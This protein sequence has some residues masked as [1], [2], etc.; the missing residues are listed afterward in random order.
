MSFKTFLRKKRKLWHKHFV[1]SL[2]AGICVA[3]VTFLFEFTAA[4]IVL[5][6]SVGASAAILANFNSHHLTKLHTTITSYVIAIIISLILY[7]LNLFLNMPLYLNLFFVVFLIGLVIYL[8]DSFHPPAISAGVSFFLFE[9]NLSDLIYLFIA[10]VVLFILIRFFTYTIS[11]RLPVKDFFV[12][13]K[14][15][16]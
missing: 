3:V 8:A 5:F 4:N 16:L 13:F 9:R 2:I 12:E 1:P 10:I 7:G 11:Q 15:E 14:R 6:A